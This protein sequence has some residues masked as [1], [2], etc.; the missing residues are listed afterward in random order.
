MKLHLGLEWRLF[1]ILTSKDID[2][3]IF[4]CNTVVVCAKIP[5]SIQ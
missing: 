2:D 3:V 1:H 4:R 5:L